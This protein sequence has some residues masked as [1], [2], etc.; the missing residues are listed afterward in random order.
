MVTLKT[1]RTFALSFPET[2]EEPHSEKTYLE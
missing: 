2:T 1:L